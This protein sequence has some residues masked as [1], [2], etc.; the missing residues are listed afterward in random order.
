MESGPKGGNNSL[1]E[2]PR[3]QESPI[4]SRLGVCRLLRLTRHQWGQ[5]ATVPRSTLQSCLVVQFHNLTVEPSLPPKPPPAVGIVNL[6]FR[7]WLAPAN[8]AVVPPVTADAP[9][10]SCCCCYGGKDN[11]SS[12]FFCFSALVPTFY[13]RCSQS[14]VIALSTSARVH[15]FTLP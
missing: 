9:A 11:I 13:I 10:V 3:L 6:E 8:Q 5:F 1:S 2:G 7:P 4:T 12:C 15:F 14:R